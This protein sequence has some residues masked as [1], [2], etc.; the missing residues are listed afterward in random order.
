MSNSKWISSEEILKEI[1]EIGNFVGYLDS[2]S[3]TLE[4]YDKSKDIAIY[5]TPNWE[6]D[7]EVPFDVVTPNDGDIHNVC[8]IKMVSGDKSS[9]LVHYLNVVMMI[10][11][12]YKDF[13][14][15]ENV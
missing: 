5:G 13:K 3:G 9:Q 2:L 4:W 15:N 14:S 1:S 10:M 8:T 6:T 12:H 7:G 11:N